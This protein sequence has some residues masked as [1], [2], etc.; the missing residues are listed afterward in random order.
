MVPPFLI[1]ALGL[2]AC[3]IRY[4]RKVRPL[5]ADLRENKVASVEG[6]AELSLERK[7]G[8]I[9]YTLAVGALR[10]PIGK[11]AFLSFKNRDPYCVY[12]APH[13]RRILSVEWLR[14]DNPFIEAGESEE[15]NPPKERQAY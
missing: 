7:G 2:G 15:S 8:G 13:S 12:Y 5:S 10:F 14:N 4:R 9:N 6:R 3:Y 1:G 11:N